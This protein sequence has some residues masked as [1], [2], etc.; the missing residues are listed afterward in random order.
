[1]KH[2]LCSIL[3]AIAI[4]LGSAAIAVTEQTLERLEDGVVRLHILANS[5]TESDQARKLLVRDA[6][7]AHAAEW[8]PD[9]D[10]RA[11]ALAGLQEHLPAIIRIAEETLHSVGC[12]DTVSAKICETEFPARTYGSV[13][14]PAGTYQALR[15]VIGS[16]EGH[17]WWC[18][19]YPTLCVPAA[20]YAADTEQAESA[21]MHAVF[22]DAVCEMTED[23]DRY[24]IRLRCVA[25]W[26][27]VKAWV[28]THLTEGA[29]T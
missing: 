16:G 24:V 9:A 12:T 14:L 28:S 27:D 3:V 23:P 17:N 1:M 13:T 25:L 20:G 6:L 7:L 10:T 22:D 21:Q 5:D 29:P 15:I 8:M 2:R 11:E 18:V 19:M 26:R 4:V